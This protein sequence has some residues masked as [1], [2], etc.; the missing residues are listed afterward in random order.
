MFD[1][2]IWPK[3]MVKQTLANLACPLSGK[4]VSTRFANLPAQLGRA[5]I[6]PMLTALAMAA[7]IGFSMSCRASRVGRYNRQAVYVLRSRLLS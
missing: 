5:V 4:L 3:E 6:F 1:Y 2:D 7:R